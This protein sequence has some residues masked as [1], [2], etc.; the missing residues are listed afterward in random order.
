MDALSLGSV[1]VSYYCDQRS[2][3]REV[4][5]QHLIFTAFGLPRPPPAAVFSSRAIAC[6]GGCAKVEALE[7]GASV[8]RTLSVTKFSDEGQS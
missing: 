4:T 1:G 2:T 3:G 6:F 7:T 8:A 5:L